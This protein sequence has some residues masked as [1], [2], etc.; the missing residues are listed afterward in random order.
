MNTVTNGIPV[1]NLI[2]RGNVFSDH[3]IDVGGRGGDL[4]FRTPD[5]NAY[6][7]RLPL[8]NPGRLSDLYELSFN[9]ILDYLEE[10]GSPVGH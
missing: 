5:I 2:I 4:N 1:A 10:L 8:G 7:D 6:L 9:D 3:L